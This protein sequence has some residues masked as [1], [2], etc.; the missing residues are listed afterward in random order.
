MLFSPLRVFIP[1]AVLLFI[2]GTILSIYESIVYHNIGTLSIVL[3]LGSL[4]IFCF[5]LLADQIAILRRTE[6]R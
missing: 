6:P 1:V 5:G 2:P 3:L 4:L